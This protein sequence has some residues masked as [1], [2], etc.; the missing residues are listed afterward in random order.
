MPGISVYPDAL[1]WG[2]RT[3][4][5]VI[6]VGGRDNHKKRNEIELITKKRLKSAWKFCKR[7]GVRAGLR[8]I[9]SGMGS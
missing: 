4:E 2:I 7:T 6:L 5:T 3:D 9:K 1:A 8:R